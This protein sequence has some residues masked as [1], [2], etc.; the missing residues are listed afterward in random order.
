MTKTPTLETAFARF[1]N[2][3]VQSGALASRRN[4][5]N[6]VRRLV[7]HELASADADI[8]HLRDALQ[9][10][11]DS[12]PGRDAEEGFDDLERRYRAM[13]AGRTA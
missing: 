12:G 4:I 11:I 1:V 10:G 3:Q 13:G 7:Q 2:A 8:Q 9:L 5:L 6:A